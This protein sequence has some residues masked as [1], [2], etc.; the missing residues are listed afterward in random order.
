MHVISSPPHGYPNDNVF[1]NEEALE[2]PLSVSDPIMSPRMDIVL[3][4]PVVPES[5]LHA[6]VPVHV[7]VGSRSGSTSG[8]TPVQPAAAE[9]MPVPHMEV[10]ASATSSP[11][12]A[13]TPRR[14]ARILLASHAIQITRED[15]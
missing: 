11:A 7:H 9:S 6:P 4:A 14:A 15:F 13:L 1:V 8:I 10:S 12:R 2:L 5:E 3:T